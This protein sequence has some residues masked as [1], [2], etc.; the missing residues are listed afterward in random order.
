[1]HIAVCDD[2]I[3]DRKQLERLLQRESD[4]RKGST[5]L[6]Y[7]ESFGDSR[8]LAVNH[9]QYDL[10][11]L[12]LS[13]EEKDGFDFAMQLIASGVSAP[14]ILCHADDAYLAKMAQLPACPSNL[15]HLKK[16]ILTAELSAMLDQAEGMKDARIPLIELRSREDTIYVAEDDIVYAVQ[17]GRYV[18][19]HLKDGR[20]IT[21][22]NSLF[23]F[24]DE[25]SMFSHIVLI[26]E[27][28]L[29]NVVYMEHYSPVSVTIKGGVKLRSTPAALRYIKS[30]LQ[31]YREETQ[32]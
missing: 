14:I 27:Q 18:Q 6:L 31:A 9:M 21:L 29:F 24:Y 2:N 17:K 23:N 20:E 1:M 30:A 22:L 10:F 16:P 13:V 4:K 26:N 8:I 3:A 25:V 12:D 32:S 28:R 11:F 15:F 7:T 5:G 19:V